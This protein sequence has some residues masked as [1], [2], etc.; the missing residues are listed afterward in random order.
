MASYYPEGECYFVRSSLRYANNWS[1][2][3]TN[4][5]YNHVL[6]E[7]YWNGWV[8]VS[9]Q[10]RSH[11]R[12]QW[13]HGQAQGTWRTR[14]GDWDRFWVGESRDRNPDNMLAVHNHPNSLNWNEC[15]DHERGG[16]RKYILRP[17]RIHNPNTQWLWIDATIPLRAIY[18]PVAQR[19]D[20]A[21]PNLCT[22]AV[23]DFR[24]RSQIEMMNLAGEVNR[25]TLTTHNGLGWRDD[26]T[27]GFNLPNVMT[28]LTIP[29]KLRN[30]DQN[31]FRPKNR[32]D[33]LVVCAW[34]GR[35]WNSAAG[36]HQAQN[37]YREMDLAQI[38]SA[39][40]GVEVGWRPYQYSSWLR[41]LVIQVVGLGLGFVP[42]I[43]P[44]L[45]VAFGMAV[46]LIQDPRSFSHENVLDLSAAV[47]DSLLQASSRSQKYLAPDFLA[48]CECDGRRKAP[49]SDE[50]RSR[51]KEIGDELNARLSED[52]DRNLVIRPL[53]EVHGDDDDD[54]KRVEEPEDTAEDAADDEAPSGQ[55]VGEGNERHE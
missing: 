43:G 17:V 18:F 13:R 53:L 40:F 46:Q 50:E 14:Y 32:G 1:A 28:Y 20:Q 30:P 6:L 34:S 37:F 8:N 27:W 41:N 31:L 16:P 54:E 25:L 3:N 19:T 45:S 52:L 48:K 4:Q 7:Y 26:L 5:F 9:Q 11:P 12:S 55:E 51:Q 23:I 44:I 2:E 29:H 22:Y 42:G 49:L 39:T 21:F 47:L 24:Q 35:R 33:E 38:L 15:R 36:I 10:T